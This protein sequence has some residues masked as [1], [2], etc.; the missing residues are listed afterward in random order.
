[1]SDLS[2]ACMDERFEGLR[3]KLMMNYLAWT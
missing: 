1:M 3:V 2:V